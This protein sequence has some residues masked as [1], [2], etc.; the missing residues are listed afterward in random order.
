[1]FAGNATSDLR[2]PEA[3]SRFFHK[4]SAEGY[5]VESIKEKRLILRCLAPSGLPIRAALAA[6]SPKGG[7]E[8]RTTSIQP[9]RALVRPTVLTVFPEIISERR[10]GRLSCIMPV[11]LLLACVP[12]EEQA[13]QQ[14][15]VTAERGLV[16]NTRR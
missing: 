14:A 11:L 12:L 3:R 13:G 4:L 9:I 1:M 15:A 8:G 10:L 7:R 16:A 6:V 2:P 5:I